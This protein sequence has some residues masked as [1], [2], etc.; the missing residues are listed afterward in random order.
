MTCTNERHNIRT[1]HWGSGSVLN[2][3]EPPESSRAPALSKVLLRQWPLEVHCRSG[4]SV[5][6]YCALQTGEEEVK[7]CLSEWYI[8]SPG[9]SKPSLE[10]SETAQYTD[11]VRLTDLG[12]YSILSLTDLHVN[13][14]NTFFCQMTCTNERHNIRTGH[15]GSGSVLNITEPPESSRVVWWV[16]SLF[17]V[18]GLVL[19]GV[20]ALCPAVL[21]RT[22]WCRRQQPALY[23]KPLKTRAR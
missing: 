14:S 20:I 7:D 18:N 17:A 22:P 23:A 4:L 16:Y 9:A 6:F 19:L 10:V 13:D 21:R 5:T 1:G 3:T 8:L 2:I 11:R 15:W 12:N